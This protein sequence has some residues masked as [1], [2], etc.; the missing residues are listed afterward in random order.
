LVTTREGTSRCEE[1]PGV[2]EELLAEAR[3]GDGDAFGELVEPYRRELQVHCYR[4]LGS[5]QDA[6]DLLQETLM[7]AWRK[8]D[9]LQRRGALR[10]WL[11][12][13]AT[14]KCLNALRDSRR[15]GS[16]LDYRPEV[17]LPEPSR[18]GEPLWIEPFP[19]VLLG[20][21]PDSAPGPE[22]RYEGVESISLAFIAAL[23]HLPPRQRAVLV[24]RD[25]LGFRAAEAAEI[26]QW[27]PD[28][29]S[30]TL[31]RARTAIGRHQSPGAREDAPLP[32]SSVERA[33]VARFA[34]A[35]ERGDVD[36]IVALLTDDAS[37]TMPPL[38]LEYEGPAVAQFLAAICFRDENRRYRLIATRANNQPAFGCYLR[39]PHAPIAHAHGLVVLTLAGGRVAG[40][41]R[42]LD[43]SVLPAFGLPRTLHE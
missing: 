27:S 24:L 19:D 25:V 1:E 6:E 8:L 26:L 3:T 41:T 23:Q 29:V 5:V 20:D 40:I 39:D 43:N 21:L 17:P 13:I 15:R 7:A 10:A 4:I 34:D 11:Y 14:N 32:S 35:F 42:F 9:Q 22:A 30:S 38:P 28:A 16:P 12:R 37:L 31:K 36:A 2:S 33:V 18:M